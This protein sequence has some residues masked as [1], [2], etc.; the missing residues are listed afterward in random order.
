MLN[1][2]EL[3]IGLDGMGDVVVTKQA[4]PDDRKPGSCIL[5][6]FVP[7]QLVAHVPSQTKPII[8][9]DNRFKHSSRGVRPIRKNL[10]SIFDCMLLSCGPRKIKVVFLF[11]DGFQTILKI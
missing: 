10:F 1:L 4:T 11:F 8:V 6:N 3:K 7:L 9:W 2:V 5:S